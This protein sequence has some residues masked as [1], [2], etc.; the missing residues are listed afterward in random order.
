[1]ALSGD[2]PSQLESRPLVIPQD[3]KAPASVTVDLVWTKPLRNK[4][5]KAGP[6]ERRDRSRAVRHARVTGGNGGFRVAG[7][8]TACHRWVAPWVITGRTGSG[9]G[10]GMTHHS[11][12]TWTR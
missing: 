8:H 9:P 2:G 4:R 6:G 7:V 3:K 1:S 12:R 11:S 5:M 10:P